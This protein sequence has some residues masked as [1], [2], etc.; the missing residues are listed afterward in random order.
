MKWVEVQIKTTTEAEELVTSIMY[1]LGVTGLAIED[2]MDILAFQQSE[3]DWDFIDPSIINQDYEGVIIKA[4]FPEDEN[5]SDKIDLVRE[6]IER[7][8][9]KERGKRLGEVTIT[10]VYEEDWAE[11]WKKY[12]KPVKIGKRIVIKPTWEEYKAGEDELI[13]ELDP[14][15][16]FG[17]GT[18]ETTMMCIEALE[19][20]V[21]NGHT[22]FDI[23][24][25]SGILSIVAAKLGAEKVVGVDLDSVCV[26]VSNENISI[27]G[28]E[29]VVETRQGN[30]FEAVHEKAHVIVANIIAEVIVE[31]VDYI[32]EY[33]FDE[34][35]FIASGIITEKLEK[36]KAKLMEKGFKILEIKCIGQ[37]ASIVSTLE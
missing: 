22:V 1:E 35:I 16:A 7:I 29:D 30:L 37:W 15:M 5:L 26:K 27:N 17:T 25:G 31:M 14:G 34:G 20:Y 8:P 4:Y 11:S 3:E 18:H 13:V 33:L 23:G 32:N 36:V 9:Y 24:C 21:K 19:D 2:P 10:E 12:Y 6:N 28:V